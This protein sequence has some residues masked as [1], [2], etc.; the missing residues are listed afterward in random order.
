LG[1]TSLN[2]VVEDVSRITSAS[3]LPLLVD[4][5]TGFGG[6]FNIART[7]KKMINAGAA[8]MH[9]E[10]QVAQKRCGHRP[11]KEIVSREEMADR[12][13]ASVDAKTDSDFIIMARTDALA[14]VGMEEV[15]ERARLCVAAGADA[16]FAEAMTDLEMY[17]QVTEAVD[18]P[19]LAN[20]T[21]FGSTPYYSTDE[22]GRAGVAMAL[23]PLSAFRAMNQA[24]LNVYKTLRAEGT[25]VNVID[26]MQTRQELYEFLGYH[27]YENKLDELFS[28]DGRNN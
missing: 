21:E 4:V 23:Y 2:D 24:A 17:R 22:L 18:V 7:V 6:A 25:Q 12:I 3:R 14:V 15:L 19:V 20:I 8:G 5:D 26:T 10:D 28:N 13:K 27:E 16:I 11:N 1:M 9:I